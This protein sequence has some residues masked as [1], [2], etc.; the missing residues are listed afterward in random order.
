MFGRAPA[1]RKASAFTCQATA[2]RPASNMHLIAI[3]RPSNRRRHFT[4]D[5]SLVEWSSCCTMNT[6]RSRSLTHLLSPSSRVGAC[7]AYAN[8]PATAPRTEVAPTPI[9]T[10]APAQAR[11]RVSPPRGGRS[12]AFYMMIMG[13]AL[14]SVPPISYFYWE[15]RKAHMK[16]V[17][18]EMLRDIQAKYKAQS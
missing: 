10:P 7:R 2:A 15:H 18:E 17:K 11:Q 1:V 5:Q 16:A 9:P 12:G 8:G 3:Y 13:G 6:P 14:L 4:R